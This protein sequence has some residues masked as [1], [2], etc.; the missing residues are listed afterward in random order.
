MRRKLELQSKAFL[1]DFLP[2]STAYFVLFSYSYSFVKCDVRE[3]KDQVAVFKSAVA[4]SPHKSVDIVIANAGIS[5]E[6]SL[7]RLGITTPLFLF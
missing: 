2:N 4:C 3:W 7:F 5:G 6:D 1:S